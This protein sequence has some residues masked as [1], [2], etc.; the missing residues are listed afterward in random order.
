MMDNFWC[1]IHDIQLLMACAN[2][3]MIFLSVDAISEHNNLSTWIHYFVLVMSFEA[4]H[5]C[6]VYMCA[7]CNNVNFAAI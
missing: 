3:Y 5:V 4:S 6:P 7:L 2:L 1:T